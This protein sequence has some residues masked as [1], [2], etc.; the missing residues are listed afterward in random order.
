MTGLASWRI[1]VPGLLVLAVGLLAAAEFLPH[2]V[3]GPAGQD[4]ETA[5]TSTESD[6]PRQ[7]DPFETSPAEALRLLR[8]AEPPVFLDVRERHELVRTGTLPGAVHI[9]LG[10]LAGRLEELD[11]REPVV[12]VCR[13]G[14]RSRIAGNTLLREGFR[15]VHNLS[16]GILRWEGPREEIEE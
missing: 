9:P 8:S 5:T 2:R 7:T 3:A 6:T 13:S 1:L 10:Q 11:P 15:E 14:R 4:A 12:V 16:G